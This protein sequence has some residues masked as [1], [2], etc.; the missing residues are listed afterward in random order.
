MIVERIGLRR[1]GLDRGDA[2]MW[3]KLDGRHV[4]SLG[5]DIPVSIPPLVIR[6]IK[7]GQDEGNLRPA[8]KEKTVQ[9]PIETVKGSI[10]PVFPSAEQNKVNPIL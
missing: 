4:T 8:T 1:P 9:Q 6:A 3:G 10:D 7:V 2:Y 5:N